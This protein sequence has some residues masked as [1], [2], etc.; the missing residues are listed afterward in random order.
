[1]SSASTS[2]SVARARGLTRKQVMSLLG[3]VPLGV[4]VVAHL[5]TNLQALAGPA[6]FDKALVASR[7][8]PAFLFLEIF[9]LAIPI[10]VHSWIGLMT[11]LKGR[12]NNLK[13]GTLRNLKYTL[14][15]L[16]GLGLLLFLG[17]HVIKARILPATEGTHVTWQGMHEALSEPITFAVYVLGLLAVSFHLANG[18][19]GSALTF[20]LTVGPKAQ[21]RM[22]WFSMLTFLG[23]LGMSAMAL[24]G[25]RPFMP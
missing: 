8:S 22:E 17:A 14:Q 19:W 4:Y 9:G 15:R 24:Y 1:M 13:Y 2:G 11:M 7:S 21:K 25:F 3:I 12:P 5:Y 18:L 16:A 23:L 10:L 20:G 6:A